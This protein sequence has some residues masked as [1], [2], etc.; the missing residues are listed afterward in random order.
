MFLTHSQKKTDTWLASPSSHP[1]APSFILQTDFFFLMARQPLGGL[2]LLIF[3]GFTITYLDT[4]D[5]VGL[6][7]TRDQP[8]A[9]TSTWQHTTLTR[10]RHPCPR[11]DSNPQSQQASGQRP[12][13]QI[14]TQMKLQ[15]LKYFFV[16][17]FS[18][19]RSPVCA[20]SNVVSDM[21]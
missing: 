7:W 1:A 8:V 12:Y 3:R 2:R 21:C 16:I 11:Q 5:S 9:E 15:N 20:R 10:D 18:F 4:P 17:F 14:K 6:L 19:S 13:K